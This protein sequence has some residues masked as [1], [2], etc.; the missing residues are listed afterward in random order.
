MEFIGLSV[1]VLSIHVAFFGTWA[2]ARR[3]VGFLYRRELRRCA[4]PKTPVALWEKGGN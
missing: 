1:W 2:I 4:I 3:V